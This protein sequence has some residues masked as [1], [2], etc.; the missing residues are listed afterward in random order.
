MPNAKKFKLDK[1]VI[2]SIREVQPGGAALLVYCIITWKN[3]NNEIKN[4]KNDIG[5]KILRGKSVVD[6]KAIS[7]YFFHTIPL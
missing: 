5:K 4:I 3:I 2:T 6:N 7:R 1:S